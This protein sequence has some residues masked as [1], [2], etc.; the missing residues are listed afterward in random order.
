MQM[1]LH[2]KT[3]FTRVT[4]V[5]CRFEGKWHDDVLTGGDLLQHFASSSSSSSSAAAAA[6][7]CN[8]QETF[9]ADSGVVIKYIK[10][11]SRAPSAEVPS[12]EFQWRNF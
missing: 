8:L 6:S 10:Q 12:T 4:R 9:A 1:K 11:S 7:D 2:S 3:H 5:C